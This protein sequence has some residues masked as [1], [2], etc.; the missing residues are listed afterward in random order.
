MVG[1]EEL[2]RL[3]VKQLK[4]ELRA[5]GLPVSGNKDV[6]IQRLHRENS[7]IDTERIPTVRSN[8]TRPILQWKRPSA[9]QRWLFWIYFQDPGKHGP[10]TP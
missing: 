5:L 8:T 6:L 7:R 1:K 3:T 10:K 4:D 2:S 9:K